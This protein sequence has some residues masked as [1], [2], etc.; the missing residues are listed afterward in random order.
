MDVMRPVGFGPAGPY[1]ISTPISGQVPIGRSTNP[2]N[3]KPSPTRG[4]TSLLNAFA[5]GLLT[6]LGAAG[7]ALGQA[8]QKLRDITPVRS[9]RSAASFSA[10]NRSRSALAASFNAFFVIGFPAAAT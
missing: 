7:E 3:T 2:R 10:F 9:K 5:V 8:R 4:L 6:L 1:P